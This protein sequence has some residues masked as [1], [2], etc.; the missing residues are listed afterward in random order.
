MQSEAADRVSILLCRRFEPLIFGDD[1]GLLRVAFISGSHDLD[2]VFVKDVQN[3]LVQK[4]I[5]FQALL[6]PVA[7]GVQFVSD[8][9]GE[10]RGKNEPRTV[11]PD[12]ILTAASR[13]NSRRLSEGTLRCRSPAAETTPLQPRPPV[14]L[15][16]LPCHPLRVGPDNLAN[17]QNCSG[18]RYFLTGGG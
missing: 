14:C 15:L 18:H 2:A 7:V 17:T 16:P 3:V 8:A 13:L 6:R 4:G 9:V 1:F 11:G 5:E 10:I 12:Q